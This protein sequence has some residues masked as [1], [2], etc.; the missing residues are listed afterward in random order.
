MD[1]ISNEIFS[2]S[3]KNLIVY[4]FKSEHFYIIADS[5]FLVNHHWGGN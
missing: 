1:E 4:L 2:F 5:L 3:S